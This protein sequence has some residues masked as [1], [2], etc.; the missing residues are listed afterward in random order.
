MTVIPVIASCATTACSYNKG[1]CSAQAI[2][3]A[4]SGK[5]VCGTLV[6]LDGRGGLASADGRVGACQHLECSHNTDLLCVADKVE[7]G[8]GGV[9]LTYAAS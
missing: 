7:V 1:G 3:V 8:A 2:T 6:E 5:A 9:C 4:G